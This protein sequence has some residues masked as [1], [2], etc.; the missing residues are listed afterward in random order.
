[1][2]VPRESQNLIDFNRYVMNDIPIRLIRLSDMKIG[3]RNDVKK[4]FR[5]SVPDGLYDPANH[6]KYAI[7]S[8]RWLDEGEPP[9]Y[10]ASSRGI[11]AFLNEWPVPILIYVKCHHVN[12]AEDLLPS[13]WRICFFDIFPSC[14][15]PWD[16][17]KLPMAITR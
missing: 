6:V 15:Y 2:M 13:V 3:G 17:F 1:M 5:N 11:K 12:L 7:L 16:L 14:E 10:H 9:F 8:H 4:H